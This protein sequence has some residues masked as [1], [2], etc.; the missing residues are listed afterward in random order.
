MSFGKAASQTN[1]QKTKI[2]TRKEKIYYSG[3]NSS[4]LANQNPNKKCFEKEKKQGVRK[5]NIRLEEKNIGKKWLSGLK[6]PIP[7]PNYQERY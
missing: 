3:I 7:M 2:T 1:L 4:I 5:K 6:L